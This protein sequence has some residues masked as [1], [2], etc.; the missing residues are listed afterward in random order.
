MKDFGFDPQ[1]ALEQVKR[2]AADA[3]AHLAEGFGRVVRDVPPERLEQ[4]MRSPARKP[5]L[6]GI[7][8]SMPKQ[9]DAAQAVGV[10]TSI[11]WDITGRS[12][13]AV[14]TYMLELDNGT[15]R[16]AH[17]AD[18]EPPRLTITMDGVEFLRLVSGNLDPMQAYFKGRIQLAG[19]IMVAAKMAQLFRMP[20]GAGGADPGD[21]P[22]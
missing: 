7:F 19:D 5:V 20:G 18:G 12:D 2:I 4:V 3:P 16:T 8:W 15:A 22:R 17:G 1:R 13:G 11:R 6:D 14:D 9:L 21:A 10:T